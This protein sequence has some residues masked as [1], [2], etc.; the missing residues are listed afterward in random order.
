VAVL[1]LVLPT[2]LLGF[3]SIFEH[4]IEHE[5]EQFIIGREQLHQFLLFDL[6]ELLNFFLRPGFHSVYV[7]IEKTVVK[8]IAHGLFLGSFTIHSSHSEKLVT[9]RFP[10]LV[11]AFQKV[12]GKVIVLRSRQDNFLSLKLSGCSFVNLQLFIYSR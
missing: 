6:R 8:H 11:H 2:T 1:L 7:N 3:L 5:G 4:L 9:K 10:L 12:I